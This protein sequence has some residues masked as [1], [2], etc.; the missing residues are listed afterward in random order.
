MRFQKHVTVHTLRVSWAAHLL[1]AGSNLRLIHAW[2]GHSSP[3][4]NMRY[5]HLTTTA[6]HRAAAVINDLLEE[7][8]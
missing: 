1:E 5:T 6:R 3:T 8:L 2:L 7:L 4:T